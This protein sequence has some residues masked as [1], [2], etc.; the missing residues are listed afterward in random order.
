MNIFQRL[1]SDTP[2]FFRVIRNIGVILAAA[3]GAILA[4]P[5][6]VPVALTTVAGYL[7]LGGTIAGAISQSVYKDKIDT[8]KDVLK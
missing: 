3:G 1:G 2:K 4:A 7:V 5:I 6:A 8:A